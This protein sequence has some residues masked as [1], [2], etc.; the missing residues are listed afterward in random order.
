MLRSPYYDRTKLLFKV[1]HFFW[2]IRLDKQFLLGG[3]YSPHFDKRP[4]TTITEL[5][6]L[7]LG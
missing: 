5:T 7:N 2:A 6:Q 4:P 1:R 3:F